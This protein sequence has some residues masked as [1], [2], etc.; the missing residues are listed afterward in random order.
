MPVGLIRARLGCNLLLVMLL[1][2]LKSSLAV[3]CS[4]CRCSL[5]VPTP[6][7]A[8]AFACRIDSSSPTRPLLRLLQV[9][10]YIDLINSGSSDS[11]FTYSGYVLP[12]VPAEG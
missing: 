5:P 3:S 9:V 8:V 12:W 2:R 6:E 11:T 10:Q 1:P 7:K 4:T